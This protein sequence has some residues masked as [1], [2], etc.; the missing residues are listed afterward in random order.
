MLDKSNSKNSNQILDELVNK[1]EKV[2]F[3]DYINTTG[4]LSRKHY[5]VSVIEILL[6]RT[7]KEKFSL[8]RKNDMVYL[9]N[10]QYWE[11][12]EIPVF[13]D[14]LEQV[15]LK[16]TVDRFDAKYHSFKDELYKQF[17]SSARL[18]E[19]PNDTKTTLI[20]LLNGTFEINGERQ[21]LRDFDKDDF[22]TYQLPFE[23]NPKA[24]AG[25][26]NIFLSE[27]LIEKELQYVLSEYLGYIFIKNNVLKL[28]K[29]LLLYG[30]GQ[31][32]KSVLFDIIS[33]LLGRQNISSLSLQS[34]T[35]KEGS[36]AMIENKLLNYASE[37]NGKLESDMFKKLASGEPVEARL[38]YNNQIEITDYARLMF[39]CNELPREVENT[40]A[41]FRRF[42]IIPF[43]VTISDEKRDPELS[44]KIIES[45]L[46]GVFNWIID[47]LK[48]LLLNKKFTESNV[49]KNEV[50]KYETESDSVLMFL[51]DENYESSI[52]ETLK[53]MDLYREYRTYCK[54]N[55]YIICSNK[56]FSQRLEKK[57]FIK[58]RTGSG[59]S[60]YIK[61]K[62]FF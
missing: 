6:D 46:S 53:T 29:V 4:K 48:R 61:K 49:V 34:L 37:I 3:N 42:I 14:F 25:R 9:Y 52:D 62:S 28:E 15:A 1:I 32:G 40:F 38:L 31:N 11:H 20:N 58:K 41:F 44:K 51:N 30:G 36:R 12:V 5:L 22:L 10:G 8:C 57:K 27:V 39:N 16:T 17:I 26:F 60:F 54:E 2:D 33:A 13:K 50:L 18:K 21:I 19:I 23:Y 47:G 35:S 55:G 59:T 45:E 7:S 56:T 43:K 24:K